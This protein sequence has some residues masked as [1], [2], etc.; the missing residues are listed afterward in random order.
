M[1]NIY[2]DVTLEQISDADIGK[3]LRA[4]G[5]VENIRDHGGVSFLDIRDMHAVLQ[6]VIRDSS[7]LKGIRKE[8]A[9]SVR[10]MVEKRD[11]ETYNPKIPTGTIELDVHEIQ[12]LGDV[13]KPLPFE[14]QASRKVRE[15][16][17]FKYRY[18]DLRNRKV[19]D[20]IVFRAK[21]LAFLRQKMTQL[22]SLG[23]QKPNLSKSSPEGARDHLS[24]STT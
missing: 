20:N 18:L 4:A 13:L 2:R 9:V 11:E 22:G 3:E 10:G 8:Q 1:K 17:R 15:D 21:V 23:I 7:L 6:A 14:I 16:V 19:M 5:W 12:V 24:T